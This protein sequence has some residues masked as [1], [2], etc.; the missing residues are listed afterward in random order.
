MKELSQK[1][2]LLVL[3]ILAALLLAEGATRLLLPPP[4]R[5]VLHPS[6]PAATPAVDSAEKVAHTVPHHLEETRLCIATPTGRRLRPNRRIT[7]ENHSLSGKRVEI[8]TNSIGLR[9]SE[10]GE[11]QGPRILFLGDSITFADYLLEEET[12]VRLVEQSARRDGRSWEAINAGI[13]AISLKTELALLLET[14]LQVE[15]D[16]VVLGFYLNDFAES[17]GVRVIHLPPLLER[18][19]FLSHVAS[20]IPRLLYLIRGE[21]AVGAQID[22]GDW[23]LWREEFRTQNYFASGDYRQEP[24]ALNALILG[25]FHDWGGA[26]SPHAWELMRPLFRELKRACDR[27]GVALAILG[28]PVQYQVEATHRCDYP[29]RKLA[30]VAAEL[31]VP[32]LDLLPVLRAA[33]AQG[34]PVL[35]YD[36]CH[37]TP[38]ASRLIADELYAFLQEHARGLQLE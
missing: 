9:N 17:P 5:I 7:I 37:N 1:L 16:L 14:G 15:P 6:P 2:L 33:Y 22:E 34:G 23:M 12:F 18:S 36:L 19:R 35:F 28:F 38:E 30:E 26:W 4:Q 10:V 25:K 27:E 11:K 21:D 13:A 32:L 20:L 8:E 29:Q 24:G 31:E 3:A